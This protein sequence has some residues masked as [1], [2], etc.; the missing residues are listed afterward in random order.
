MAAVL[1]CGPGALLSHRS[2]AALWD[3]RGTPSGPID[4]VST[5]RHR[6]HGIRCHRARSLDPEDGTD[7][8]RDPRDHAVPDPPRQ[9]R[10][11]GPQRLRTL[12]EAAIREDLL[13]Q[14]RASTPS[15][16][17][18]SAATGCRS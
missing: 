12:V 10:G 6:I 1:A 13:D 15:S 16:P 14:A 17:A 7:P 2:A 4:V 5:S 8:R 11:R 3:L 18:V 9:R